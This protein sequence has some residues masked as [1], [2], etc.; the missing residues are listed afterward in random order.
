MRCAR[1]RLGY[2]RPNASEPPR[3]PRKRPEIRSTRWIDR[4]Y[5]DDHSIHVRVQGI[6]AEEFLAFLKKIEARCPPIWKALAGSPS[7]VRAALHPNQCVMVEPRRAV[8]RRTDHQGTT[9]RHPHL[10]PPTQPRRSSLDRYL[11]R[12]PETLRMDQ[13]ELVS[14][15]SI[16][17]P[18]SSYEHDPRPHRQRISTLRPARPRQQLSTLVIG[19]VHSGSNRNRHPPSL[20]CGSR[21]ILEYSV[22]NPGWLACADNSDHFGRSRWR[23]GH[24]HDRAVASRCSQWSVRCRGD[25]TRSAHVLACHMRRR[26]KGSAAAY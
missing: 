20:P 1:R 14:N 7:A 12:Q 26:P 23:H 3:K 6:T 16:A 24:R 18:I 17:Q 5:V 13:I 2:T 15:R 9:P 25:R 8:V 21:S 22:H 19:Q 11:E 4:L 10:G